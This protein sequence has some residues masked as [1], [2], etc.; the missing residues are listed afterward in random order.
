MKIT[1]LSL[2]SETFIP[3]K[4]PLQLCSGNSY[5]ELLDFSC[6]VQLVLLKTLMDE[7]IVKIIGPTVSEFSKGIQCMMILLW[8]KPFSDSTTFCVG[9][10]A[11]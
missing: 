8:Q 5:R 4:S 1:V 2:P 10:V 7:T 11:P 9:Y 6:D 3:R